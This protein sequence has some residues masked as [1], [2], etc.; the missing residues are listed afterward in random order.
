M[1]A[2]LHRGALEPKSGLRDARPPNRKQE[3][4]M[5]GKSHLAI[6]A[7]AVATSA[8][9]PSAQA[10]TLTLKKAGDSSTPNTFSAA[11]TWNEN[12]STATTGPQPGDTV[13]INK[14]K[15]YFAAETFDIGAAGLTIDVRNNTTSCKVVFTGSGTLCFTNSLN[16]S[17][18]FAFDTTTASSYTGGT[19]ISGGVAVT[20][21]ASRALGSGNIIIDC[22]AASSR[23]H[24]IQDSRTFYNDI[25]IK[26]S[27]TTRVISASNK[28]T[29]NGRIVGEDDSFMIDEEY[30]DMFL[31]GDVSVPAG[32]TITLRGRSSKANTKLQANGALNGNLAVAGKTD[33]T[34]TTSPVQLN[35]TAVCS[36]TTVSV[37]ATG[38]LQLTASE[39]LN[40]NA[41]LTV[42]EGGIVEVAADVVV[43]VKAFVVGDVSMPVGCYKSNALPDVISGSGAI[44]V[45]G[46][47]AD[48]YTWTGA[49]AN[50][51]T[52]WY[53][54]A[55][56]DRNEVPSSG[57][58]AFFPSAATIA[59]NSPSQTIALGSEGLTIT[60]A[61][62]LNFYIPFSGSGAVTFA[63][64]STVNFYC[65]SA[66]TGGTVVGARTTITAQT[67]TT[68]L[69]TG[70]VAIDGSSGCHPEVKFALY[71]TSVPNAIAIRGLITANER[72]ALYISNPTTFSGAITGDDDIYLLDSYGTMSFNNAVSVPT[73]KTIHAQNVYESQDSRVIA[74]KAAINGNLS[75]EKKCTARLDADAVCSGTA[76]SVAGNAV[77]W[78]RGKG[79]LREDAIITVADG[80]RITIDA[81]AK[82]A[83]AE[84]VANGVNV[85]HGHY[86]AATLPAVLTGEGR[87]RVGPPNGFML[88]VR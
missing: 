33:V 73:G 79:N 57:A 53:A 12:G 87:L 59:T 82:A 20:T 63:T 65:P 17:K 22:R 77:L 62:T 24:N 10:R 30:G 42:T 85:P 34:K 38:W 23:L 78:L 31:N 72:G 43:K 32:K 45:T 60:A 9:L 16:T 39:N 1:V 29:L 2:L 36:G 69:G 76:I 40:P 5:K 19:I 67:K 86:T 35:T 66:H 71:G 47:N 58:I 88:V 49:D 15:A 51:P 81:G 84:L 4:T 11:A 37:N 83:V 52:N 8:I 75:V 7:A 70:P 18:T 28:V 26:G 14:D 48:I 27:S 3:Q 80:G 50:N 61:S 25:T 54:S 46:G 55:N 64:S 41:S 6:L 74:F 44:F 13:V 56:W 21:K 68:P